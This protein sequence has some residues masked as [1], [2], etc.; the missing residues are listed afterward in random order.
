M[1]GHSDTYKEGGGHLL[2]VI[3]GQSL[4]M[5]SAWHS[6]HTWQNMHLAKEHSPLFHHLQTSW[7]CTGD[8]WRSGRAGFCEGVGLNEVSQAGTEMRV[9]HQSSNGTCKG[10]VTTLTCCVLSI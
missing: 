9:S 8:C 2:V 7:G 10:S 1:G 4:A 6:M 5:C 3:S